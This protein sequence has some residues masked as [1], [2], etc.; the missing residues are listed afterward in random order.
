MPDD[1]TSMVKDAADRLFRQSSPFPAIRAMES[2]G[3]DAGLWNRFEAS[4]FAALLAPGFR[5]PFGAGTSGAEAVE[6]A[7]AALELL[8]SAG[9]RHAPLPVAESV[10]VHALAA[11][12]GLRQPAG[13]STCLAGSIYSTALS[14]DEWSLSGEARR[15]PWARHADQFLVISHVDGQPAAGW[16]R[17]EAPGVLVAWSSNAAAE[18]RDD[19]K[20][21]GARVRLHLLRPARAPGDAG[22]PTTTNG[23][24]A[25]LNGEITACLPALCTAALMT[26]A[27]EG[28]LEL[29]VRYASE[30]IQFGQPIMRF[31]AVQQQLAVLAG[32]VASARAACMLAFAPPVGGDWRRVAVAKVRAGVAARTA[33]AVAHQVHGAIGVTQEYPLHLLTRRLWSWRAENGADMVWAEKLGRS[34]IARGGSRLWPDLVG[35]HREATPH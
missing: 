8:L 29:A 4:E 14:T 32:E 23:T 21:D 20:L 27:A 9:H 10:V 22:R 34:V 3:Y 19:V 16:L 17:R 28:A 24:Q 25:A 30:R 13:I 31:Q 18:P 1:T 2:G 35:L 5:P 11:A 26:G 15:V 33:A 6:A 7:A 12:A